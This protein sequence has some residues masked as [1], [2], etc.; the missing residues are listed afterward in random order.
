MTQ[1]LSHIST[2]E[3]QRS[4]LA[5]SSRNGNMEILHLDLNCRESLTLNDYNLVLF[6]YI[7]QNL[8]LQETIKYIGILENKLL[9]MDIDYLP[10]CR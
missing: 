2:V 1:S 9:G 4:V 7:S 10:K 6:V 5:L 3:I 8:I